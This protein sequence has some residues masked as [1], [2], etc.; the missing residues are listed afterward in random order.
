MNITLI[1]SDIHM[2]VNET[3]FFVNLR[4]SYHHATKWGEDYE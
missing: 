4:Y 2:H 3:E 1:H